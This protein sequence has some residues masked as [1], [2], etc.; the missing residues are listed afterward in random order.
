MEQR[1][2]ETVMTMQPV[3]SA[4]VSESINLRQPGK[5]FLSAVCCSLKYLQMFYELGQKKGFIL[6]LFEVINFVKIYHLFDSTVC[7]TD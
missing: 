6:L 2:A 4:S 7:M 3:V 1:E 5:L